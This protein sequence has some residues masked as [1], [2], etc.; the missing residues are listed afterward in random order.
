MYLKSK[1]PTPIPTIP[2]GI[3]N[4]SNLTSYSR[5]KACKPSKSITSKMG[6]KIAAAWGTVMAM[7]MMGTAKDPKPA[8]NPLLLRPS[9]KTAGAAKA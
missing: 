7:A 2:Q 1:K 4:F 9:N 5:R 3:K 6:I 8:P